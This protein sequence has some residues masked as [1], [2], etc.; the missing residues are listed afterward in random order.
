VKIFISYRRED[1]GGYS[2]MVADR[3]GKSFGRQNVF[4]DIDSIRP[5]VDFRRAVQDEVASCDVLIALIGRN[6]LTVTDPDG[7]RRLDMP[8]DW[9][10]LEIATA[11]ARQDILV[12]PTLVHGAKIPEADELPE[13]LQD[14]A[15]RNAIELSDARFDFDTERLMQALRGSGAP[16]GP[17]RPAFWRRGLSALTKRLPRGRA[18]LV[19][20]AVAVPLL[21]V[22]A[23]AIKLLLGILFPGPSPGPLPAMAMAPPG[24]GPVLA[25]D[26]LSDGKRGSL[27]FPSADPA[28]YRLRFVGGE[29]DLNVVDGTWLG[30][31]KDLEKPVLKVPAAADMS[32]AVDA[33]LVGTLGDRN[34]SVR[35]RVT[36]T[37]TYIGYI[38]W[39][40]PVLRSYTLGMDNTDGTATTLKGGHSTFIQP[41]IHWNRLQLSCIGDT[42]TAVINGHRVAN[43]R[44]TH[45]PSGTVGIGTGTTAL[46][47][48]LD[49]HFA[50]LEVTRPPT[51]VLLH[52]AAP[53]HTGALP[54]ST[55]GLYRQA[56][57]G[58][59][60]LVGVYD[61]KF[62]NV[63][64]YSVPFTSLG[65]Q[66]DSTIALD[67][68]VN[69]GSDNAFVR[70]TCRRAETSD[71]VT[72]YG[73][74]LTPGTRS[75]ALTKQDATGALKTLASKS[76]VSSINATGSNHLELDCIG[77][78]LT[79][80]IN[81]Q[82]VVTKHDSTFASGDVGLSL[83]DTSAPSVAA[84][85]RNI[86]VSK[87]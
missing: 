66:I 42:I 27:P 36:D 7:R 9:V 85:F 25:S 61:Q 63:H 39:V 12:V 38:L 73:F 45:F 60:Y 26:P 69:S 68:A 4:M 24:R 43:V 17:Q 51:Q 50:N 28:H 80:R 22:A 18:L 71:T 76:G 54:Q 29:Y 65:T 83:G 14:L 84:A 70:L 64:A 19:P 49:A 40:D 15:W 32:I 6:W 79:G 87:P 37:P 47:P 10:R 53:G 13:D 20:L 81:G 5:G 82:T 86:V 52:D 48:N 77:N 56:Y 74:A 3:L 46:V 67:V 33:R 11:L 23:V 21:V 58:S 34:V 57:S 44:D 2:L 59:S 78:T 8:H 75:W 72:D 41:G 31:S 1:T 62:L 16:A 55:S 30:A 35:C